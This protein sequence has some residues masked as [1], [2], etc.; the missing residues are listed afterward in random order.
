M[1]N[2]ARDARRQ[3]LRLTDRGLAVV[4][5][6]GLLIILAVVTQSDRLP[7]SYESLRAK[8]CA[9]APSLCAPPSVGGQ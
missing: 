8:A 3:P 7:W 2:I 9:D 5:I 6:L 4:A 1:P